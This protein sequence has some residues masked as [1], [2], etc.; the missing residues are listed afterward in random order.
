MLFIVIKNGSAKCAVAFNNNVQNE[1]KIY[2]HLQRDMHNIKAVSKFNDLI[3]NSSVDKAKITR[4]I[5]NKSTHSFTDEVTLPL[6]ILFRK[7]DRSSPT[8]SFLWIYRVDCKL[9]LTS[10]DEQRHH[11]DTVRW[12]IFQF[13]SNP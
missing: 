13:F 12:K 1:N 10:N 7:P 6:F 5:T 9:D 3:Q 4:S 8:V 2:P 11:R